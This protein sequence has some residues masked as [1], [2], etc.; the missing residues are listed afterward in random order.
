MLPQTTRFHRVTMAE[1]EERKKKDKDDKTKSRYD[2]DNIIP[3]DS[4]VIFKTKPEH[5]VS[6]IDRF[7]LFA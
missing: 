5:Q 4:T 1:K 7:I 6:L 2:E 3:E